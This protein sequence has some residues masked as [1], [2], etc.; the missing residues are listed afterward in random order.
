MSNKYS[1]VTITSKINAD[2]T[3]ATQNLRGFEAD[4]GRVG[5]SVS[6]TNSELRDLE[7]TSSTITSEADAAIASAQE[8][9]A[10]LGETM[11]KLPGDLKNSLT[12]LKTAVRDMDLGK[13]IDLESQLK[14]PPTVKSELESIVALG[15]TA[16]KTGGAGAYNAIFTPPSAAASG[17]QSS[18]AGGGAPPPPKSAE[19][20]PRPDEEPPSGR[21]SGRSYRNTFD[22]AERQLD[23]LQTNLA[24]LQKGNTT[25]SRLGTFRGGV[26]KVEETLKLADERA[27][28]SKD[29]REVESLQRR[30]AGLSSSFDELSEGHPERRRDGESTKD[31]SFYRSRERRMRVLGDDLDEIDPVTA[32]RATLMGMRKN[33]RDV[34]GDVDAARREGLSPERVDELNENLEKLTAKLEGNIR[35]YNETHG[36]SQQIEMLGE[37]PPTQNP[38]M[39][40]LQD[41]LGRLGG[42]GLGQMGGLGRLAGR[43]GPW[44]LAAGAVVGGFNL[45]DRFMTS[46][47]RQ[48][49][50]ESIALSDLGRQYGDSGES[51]RY[52]RSGSGL[53]DDEMMKLGY[54]GT[55]AARVAATYDLPG[56]GDD[57]RGFIEDSTDILKLSRSTGLD[58]N[59]VASSARTLGVAGVFDRGNADQGAE[60]L[61]GAVS[62]GLKL[63]ISGSDTMRNLVGMVESR[64]REG[65]SS[66]RES[67]AFEASMQRSL[68][69]TGS[70][71]MQGD[72]GAQAQKGIMNALTGGEDPALR[73]A[74]HGVVG[75][76]SA[77]DLGMVDED[78]SINGAG[79]QYD[80]LREQSPYTAAEIALE[81]VEDG[82]APEVVPQLRD[83]QRELSGGREELLYGIIQQTSGLSAEQTLEYMSNDGGIVNGAVAG[84]S[85]IAE[86]ISEDA[87]GGNTRAANARTRTAIDMDRALVKSVNALQTF[88]DTLDAFTRGK[89][90]A[91]LLAGQFIP[92]IA[93]DADYSQSSDDP[94]AVNPVLRNVKH[95]DERTYIRESKA[96]VTTE[97]IDIP[98]PR[99]ADEVAPNDLAT[100]R[101]QDKPGTF[102]SAL[103]HP[104][105]TPSAAPSPTRPDIETPT[106]VPTRDDD[107][108]TTPAP[109]RTARHVA[110][111]REATRRRGLG[112]LVE[113]DE[114]ANAVITTEPGEVY[115]DDVHKDLQGK[116]HQG[117]DIR[118]GAAGRPDPISNPFESAQL[119]RA[120]E[121]AL[122]GN[123]GV[124]E[125][126]TGDRY[127]IGHLNESVADDLGKRYARGD[128]LGIEGNSGASTGYHAHIERFDDEGDEEA[129]RDNTDPAR[130]WRRFE[131]NVGAAPAT[132][133]SAPESTQRVEV[134]VRGLERVEVQGLGPQ[135]TAG[136][137]GAVEAFGRAI[138]TPE[139]Y[140]GIG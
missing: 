138:V 19:P 3:S 83:R 140:G 26:G 123:Y 134:V 71:V 124:F 72:A 8:K 108:T 82:R 95:S 31:H 73:Y 25:E 63:G 69:A 17:A 112:I 79:R 125:T 47:T 122:G 30:L 18:G 70:V 96:R 49:A 81:M 130:F 34:K 68:A 111:R 22:S 101:I 98:T 80:R 102:W 38:M 103:L 32:Q 33:V 4:V 88:G 110:R 117:F 126:Q 131:D 99:L 50:D 74:M 132:G 28:S 55:D 27:G 97:Q 12:D 104:V 113:G 35:A 23:T 121:S 86:D 44:G 60:I 78:G 66:T 61:K 137:R 75:G 84:M 24:S 116:A 120:G 89:L 36:T 57:R 58:E 10:R 100:P 53:S 39:R 91:H 20:P 48:A 46:S 135:G 5:K 77:A 64:Y 109:A 11:A 1:S 43:L 76:L 59:R 14:L 85:E 29:K 90:E 118:I 13:L 45:A 7:S 119:V 129:H 114:S 128:V 87:Q 15:N 67:L 51:F 107:E 2:T 21:R 42:G 37:K 115:G 9:W 54:T 16:S 65:R 136:I 94:S 92:D 52:F 62:E 40:T 133:A 105:R 139:S 106:R 6:N 93:E 127:K 56:R 41:E